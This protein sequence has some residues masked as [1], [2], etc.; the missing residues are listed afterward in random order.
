M[1]KLTPLEIRKLHAVGPIRN[2]LSLEEWDE[3]ATFWHEMANWAY[4][5]VS[6]EEASTPGS[7]F[8]VCSDTRKHAFEM[9][10]G[11]IGLRKLQ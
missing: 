6:L 5:T 7:F 2:P 3:L 1:E 11:K 8:K 4:W 10:A 9:A